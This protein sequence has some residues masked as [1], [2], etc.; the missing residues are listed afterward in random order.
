MAAASEATE[1]GGGPAA[2]AA[3]SQAER[4]LI[5]PRPDTAPSPPV[6]SAMP[7]VVL[8]SWR[9]GRALGLPCPLPSGVAG[10]WERPV[11]FHTDTVKLV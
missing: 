4:R 7:C 5:T 10:E 11:S 2:G 1:E 9:R 3:A 6:L 8:S